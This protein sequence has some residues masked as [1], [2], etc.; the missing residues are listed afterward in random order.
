[1]PDGPSSGSARQVR[2]PAAEQSQARRAGRLRLSPPASVRRF[3]PGPALS[4]SRT[5]STPAPLLVRPRR[6]YLRTDGA[7]RVAPATR[8]CGSAKAGLDQPEATVAL[9]AKSRHVLGLRRGACLRRERRVEIVAFCLARRPW[10]H[11]PGLV[12]V[13]S[14]MLR[15]RPAVHGSTDGHRQVANGIESFP[16]YVK[17]PRSGGVFS[18]VD[19][20]RVGR[21]LP[22]G[23]AR[24]KALH[25]NR[26][27]FLP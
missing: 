21:H 27:Q 3:T 8:T 13:P 2:L 11:P 20:S 25:G 6:F 16:R 14:P 1:M 26:G 18:H 24:V 4:L 5:S 19:G 17:K 10:E 7:M 23:Q 9:V 15:P 22:S 12:R